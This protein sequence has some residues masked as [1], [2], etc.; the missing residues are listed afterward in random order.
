VRVSVGARFDGWKESDG[1]LRQTVIATGASLNDDEYPDRSGT[2]FSPS[3]GITW[4]VSKAWRLRADAQQGFRVPTLNELYRP[5]R[6]GSNITEANPDLQTEHVTSGEL[7]ADGAFGHLRVG[8]AAFASLLRDAVDAV[9][10]A[11]GPAN[12]PGIGAIPA[13]GTGLERLNLDR[14]RVA[15]A[16]AYAEWRISDSLRLRADVL[17]ENTDI[18]RASV[19]PALV[20]NRLVQVPDFTVVAGASWS[21]PGGIEVTPRLRWIGAQFSDDQNQLRQTAVAVADLSLSRKLGRHAR[22]VLTVENLGNA[23]IETDVS[24]NGVINVGEPRLAFV[25]IRFDR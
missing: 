5:F 10:I 2:E 20:G 18:L 13:G 16:R 23:R 24:S 12:V 22:L 3:A 6:Q 25:A 7:G 8:V 9:T 21:A 15:G 4:Q 14:V 19:N 11:N 17:A 1:H